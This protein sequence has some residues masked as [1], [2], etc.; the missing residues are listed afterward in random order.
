MLIKISEREEEEIIRERRK[1]EESAEANRNSLWGKTKELIYSV[2]PRG[3]L[4]FLLVMLVAQNILCIICIILYYS[5]S[6]DKQ[7][8]I[9]W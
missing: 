9:E 1:R 4:V 6:F 7:S 5:G 2:V 3:V 8:K